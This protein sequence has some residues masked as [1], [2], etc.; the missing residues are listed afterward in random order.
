[1]AGEGKHRSGGVEKSTQTVAVRVRRGHFAGFSRARSVSSSCRVGP[2]IGTT[3]GRY[4]A[5]GVRITPG[6]DLGIG[7]TRRASVRVR[8]NRATLTPR[9][10]LDSPSSRLAIVEA[11][12]VGCGTSE[13]GAEV[14]SF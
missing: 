10:A 14:T 1:M 7:P 12:H 2:R 4:N 9:L 3:K 11:A 13:L 5:A 6:F 8:M